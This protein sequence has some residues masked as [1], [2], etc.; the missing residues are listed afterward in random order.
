MLGIAS[1]NHLAI[2]ISTLCISLVWL[3]IYTRV[4]CVCGTP[5]ITSGPFSTLNSFL[6]TSN[7][8]YSMA[9]TSTIRWSITAGCSNSPT[10]PWPSWFCLL[11]SQEVRFSDFHNVLFLTCSPIRF[12]TRCGS[13][14]LLHVPDLPIRLAFDV[15]HLV[16]LALLQVRGSH[17]LPLSVTFLI[18]VFRPSEIYLL[19]DTYLLVDTIS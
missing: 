17:Q 9:I 19:Q 10:M 1:F 4:L 12:S 15:G 7:S 5:S 14:P 8:S 18:V 6:V 2:L 11:L 16:L 3:F 13:V